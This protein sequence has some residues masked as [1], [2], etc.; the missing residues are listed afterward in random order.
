MIIYFFI[1]GSNTQPISDIQK[2]ADSILCQSTSP[3]KIFA[4]G[5]IIDNLDSSVQFLSTSSL[6][7][8]AMVNQSVQQVDDPFIL[9]IDNHSSPVRLHVSA[10]DIFSLTMKR[11]PNASLIYSDY[12]LESNGDIQEIH[13]LHHHEG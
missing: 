11:N 6:N 7:Y 8:A 10:V 12:D 3:S 5:D 9:L 2:T 13:L 1:P 4:V